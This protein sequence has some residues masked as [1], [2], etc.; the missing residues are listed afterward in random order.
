MLA[1]RRERDKRSLLLFY[2]LKD[3]PA[4]AIVVLGPCKKDVLLDMV[5]L[6]S[7]SKGIKSHFFVF[8]IRN[9]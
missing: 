9:F 4:A 2:L 6:L 8:I 3:P 7:C 1:Y 5:I